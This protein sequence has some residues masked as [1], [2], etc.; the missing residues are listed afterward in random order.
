MAGTNT[1]VVKAI[2]WINEQRRDY[3]GQTLSVLID[4]ASKKFDLSPLDEAFIWRQFTEGSK[5]QL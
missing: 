4:E 3:P 1:A 2:T 5:A